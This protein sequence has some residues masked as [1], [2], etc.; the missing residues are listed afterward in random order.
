[1]FRFTRKPSSGSHSHYLATITH[2]VKSGYVEVVQEF[3]NVMAACCIIFLL[4]WRN[5]LKWAKASS[6]SR[7]YDHT[8]LDTPPFG[9]TLLDERPARRKY[10]YLT[11]QNTD[12]RQI[13]PAGFETPIPANERPQ[14]HALDHAATGIGFSSI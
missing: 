2:L 3:V 8:Q 12:K 10:L 1:M 14:T 9:R 13:F 11:A 4:P 6:M 5:S 7:I